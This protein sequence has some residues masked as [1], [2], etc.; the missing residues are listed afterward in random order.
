MGQNLKISRVIGLIAVIPARN[1]YSYRLNS[2]ENNLDMCRRLN[3]LKNEAE[4]IKLIF[5]REGIESCKL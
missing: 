3:K 2:I 1:I 5:L 4:S